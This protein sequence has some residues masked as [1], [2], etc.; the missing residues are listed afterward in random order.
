MQVR[1]ILAGAL[2]M[3]IKT[4]ALAVMDTLVVMSTLAVSDASAQVYDLSG[5]YQCIRNCAG[6]G[7]AFVTQNGWELN[8]VNEIWPAVAGLGGLAGPYLGPILE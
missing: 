1:I 4:M 7:T 8:L 5:P 3:R 6:P 2:V